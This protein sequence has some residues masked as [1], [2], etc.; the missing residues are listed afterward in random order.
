MQKAG[1]HRI[2]RKSS[3]HWLAFSDFTALSCGRSKKRN[4]GQD[5]SSFPFS[6]E[7]SGNSAKPQIVRATTRPLA[8]PKKRS[9]PSG[10]AHLKTGVAASIAGH[11]SLGSTCLRE[12]SLIEILETS[13]PPV[14]MCCVRARLRHL[15]TLTGSQTGRHTVSQSVSQSVTE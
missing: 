6:V 15:V 5:R 1:F 7:N 3:S 12:V 14:G 4:G 10:D 8:K 9:C 2:L 11:S 13:G